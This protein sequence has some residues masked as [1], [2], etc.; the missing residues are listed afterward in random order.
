MREELLHHL[1]KNIS[2]PL[3]NLTTTSGEAV[4]II[5]PGYYNEHAGPDFLEA[6]LVI[7]EQ[8]WVGSI[9]IH[10]KSSDWN[11]H[12]HHKDHRYNNV[13]L[14]LVWNE[15]VEINYLNGKSIPTVELK[16]FI[17]LNE[18]LKK[19]TFFKS[20][21]DH[22][23]VCQNDIALI[24]PF[25][26]LSWLNRLYYERLE[27]KCRLINELLLNTKYDWEAV[28]FILLLRNFGL[29]QNKEIFYQLSKVIGYAIISRLQD[30]II[31]MESALFGYSGL[32]EKPFAKDFYWKS[33]NDEFT[34][35]KKKFDFPERIIQKPYF[36]RLR[37]ASFPTVRLSQFAHLYHTN[38][39]L[40]SRIIS[41]DNKNDLYK[42]FSISPGEYWKTHYV[43]G[44][45]S[46]AK[47]EHKL[48]RR[49]IDSLLINS[50]IPLVFCYS[51]WLGEPLKKGFH[52]II[53]EIKSEENKI[54]RGYRACGV[55]SKSALTSQALI[56]LYNNYC[57]K[58]R[59]LECV[60]GDSILNGK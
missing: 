51:K 45:K 28:L 23:I 10:I 14:H 58:H 5:S 3:L 55:H 1:W 8:A 42:L 43:F 25:K 17:S 15:D 50:I 60:I 13:I 32:L 27:E 22:F 19:S 44:K 52:E 30:N 26:I 59:C 47:N 31:K 33:L 36:F 49:F 16:N 12:N 21:R 9:E 46:L 40:F 57:A 37:P 39:K 34:F 11:L 38:P 20:K 4:D 35:L 56:H 48:S 53:N 41:I 2:P 18:I 6:H 29:Y 54:T 24:E 7:N